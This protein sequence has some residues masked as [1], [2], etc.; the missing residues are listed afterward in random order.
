[1][2]PNILAFDDHKL[3]SVPSTAE[4][5]QF[6]FQWLSDAE[7]HLHTLNQDAL[8]A[9]QPQF[10][11]DLVRLITYPSVRPSKPVRDLVARCYV[12]LYLTGETRTLLDTIQRLRSLILA[13]Q[14]SGE[15]R[16]TKMAALH[17]L[18]RL[19]AALGDRILSQFTDCALLAL[20]FVRSSDSLPLRL[21]AM[22][23]LCDMLHGAGRIATDQTA[24]E[25]A[26]ALRATL[27]EKPTCIMIAA[28]TATAALVQHTPYIQHLTPADLDGF[29]QSQMRLLDTPVPVLRH[30]VADLLAATLGALYRHRAL[31]DV[32]GIAAVAAAASRA[33]GE[34]GVPT[35]PPVSRRMTRSMSSSSAVGV[36]PPIAGTDS[37]SM[38]RTVSTTASGF[39]QRLS[40]TTTPLFYSVADILRYLSAAFNRPA[41]SRSFRAGITAAYRRLLTAWGT[42]L[43]EQHLPAILRHVLVDLAGGV[44]GQVTARAERVALRVLITDLLRRG[45]VGDLLSDRGRLAAAR[46]ILTQWVKLPSQLPFPAPAGRSTASTTGAADATAAREL[47]LLCALHTLAGLLARLGND[48]AQIQ[49]GMTGSLLTLLSYPKHAVQTAAALCLREFAAAVPTRLPRLLARLV[50]LLQKDVAN[51][52]NTGIS[53]GVLKRCQGYALGLAAAVTVVGRRPL[54]VAHDLLQ[55]VAALAHQL[56]RSTLTTPGHVPSRLPVGGTPLPPTNTHPAPADRRVANA[57]LR[58]GWTLV[59][60]LLTLGPDVAQLHLAAWFTFWS[61]ALPDEE[62]PGVASAPLTDHEL[63]HRYQTREAALAALY[64]LLVFNQQLVDSADTARRALGLLRATLTFL[65]RYP[66]V[67]GSALLS[68]APAGSSAT[69]SSSATATTTAAAA[70]LPSTAGLLES[71]FACRRRLMACFARLLP[72]APCESL[73][74]ALFRCAQDLVTNPEPAFAG[75]GDFLYARAEGSS[76]GFTGTYLAHVTSPAFGSSASRW[77][78]EVSIGLSSLLGRLLHEPQH[79]RSGFALTEH[80]FNADDRD[81]LDHGF[82]GVPEYDVNS[83][84]APPAGW[85]TGRTGSDSLAHDGSLVVGSGPPVMTGMAGVGDAGETGNGFSD[86]EAGEEEEEAAA[87]DDDLGEDVDDDGETG[88]LDMADQPAALAVHPTVTSLPH[89]TTV[90]PYTAAIDAAVELFGTLFNHT[91]EAAQTTLLRDLLAAQSYA[92]YD[93]HPDRRYAV[94]VNGVLALFYALRGG[95]YGTARADPPALASRVVILMYEVL[96]APLLHSDVRLRIA[97]GET[98]GLLAQRAGAKFISHTVNQ[99]TMQAI[100]NRDPFARAGV[101]LGLGSIYSHAGSMTASVH[102]KSVVVLLH[103]LARD[104]HPVVHRWGL[105][106]LGMTIDAA[107]LMFVPYVSITVVLLTKLAASESH[108]HPLTAEPTALANDLPAS[109]ALRSLGQVLHAVLGAYGPELPLDDGLRRACLALLRELRGPYPAEYVRCCQQVLMFAPRELTTGPLLR[110]LRA[111]LVT[112]DPEARTAGAAG[113]LQ[114]VKRDASEVLHSGGREAGLP[115][116]FALYDA[117]PNLP[118]LGRAIRGLLDQAV[119]EPDAAARLGPLIRTLRTIVT[120]HPGGGAEAARNDGPA[121]GADDHDEEDASFVGSGATEGGSAGVTA[122]GIVLPPAFTAATRA[123][124]L[125]CLRYLLL[126]YARQMPAR[127]FDPDFRPLPPAWSALSGG[128]GGGVAELV[129]VA[130]IAASGSHIRLQREGLALLYVLLREFAGYADPDFTSVSLL[131]QYQAQ[132]TAAFAPL[133][134]VAGNPSPA[135]TTFPPSVLL[136]AVRLGVAFAVS[137]V[138]RDAAPLRRLLRPLAQPLHLDEPV[139]FDATT[140]QTSFA[141]DELSAPRPPAGD[142]ASA[143]ARERAISFRPSPTEAAVTEALAPHTAALLRLRLLRAWADLYRASRVRPYLRPLVE[144]QLGLLCPLWLDALTDAVLIPLDADLFTRS[145]TTAWTNASS[146]VTVTDGTRSEPPSPVETTEPALARVRSQAVFPTDSFAGG[147]GEGSCSSEVDPADLAKTAAGRSLGLDASAVAAVRTLL[148]GHLGREWVPIVDAFGALLGRGA[149]DALATL[150]TFNERT[151]SGLTASSSAPFPRGEY[152]VYGLCVR[153][154]YTAPK[155]RAHAA[156]VRVCLRTLRRVLQSPTPGPD[157]TTPLPVD[158]TLWPL[159]MP[160]AHHRPF[161]L[162]ALDD[163]TVFSEMWCVLDRLVQLEAPGVRRGIVRLAT[164]VVSL[165]QSNLLYRDVLVD[166]AAEPTFCHIRDLPASSR[167]WQVLA[168]LLSVYKHTRPALRSVPVTTEHSETPA[169]RVVCGS[170]DALVHLLQA[171]PLLPPTLQAEIAAMTLHLLT[172]L[173][174]DTPLA[175]RNAGAVLRSLRAWLS[176]DYTRA[177]EAASLPGTLPGESLVAAVAEAL[178]TVLTRC[179]VVPSEPLYRDQ[180]RASLGFSFAALL[181]SS[182][183][184]C[185]IPA[186]L[187]L[188]YLHDVAAALRCPHFRLATGALQSVRLLFLQISA[189]EPADA[190]AAATARRTA[191]AAAYVL[192]PELVDLLAELHAAPTRFDAG[193]DDYAHARIQMARADGL[194]LGVTPEA[195]SRQLRNE[196]PLSIARSV[197][198][199]LVQLVDNIPADQVPTLFS[200]VLPSLIFVLRDD[201]T[202][203][204]AAPQGDVDPIRQGF[205][206]IALQHLI[207][208][209]KAYSDAFKAVILA[210]EPD[211]QSKLQRALRQDALRHAPGATTSSAMGGPSGGLLN[212]SGPNSVRSN[213][214]L[215]GGPKI[216]LRTSFNSFA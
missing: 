92:G 7:S 89:A 126:R 205:H 27:T 197:C 209:A 149:P 168:L 124:A 134:A 75:M 91:T 41:A 113:L 66:L 55:W 215:T 118:D 181:V 152:L 114:L 13:K 6:I 187:V 105:H 69:S 72:H 210:L 14:G 35:G 25:L 16:E 98:L 159:A 145:A 122:T 190:E 23:A 108:A 48:A 36:S 169:V 1:M 179:C 139:D 112:P 67:N 87:G 28:T 116:L 45:V 172:Q 166:P 119:T 50:H 151:A 3:Q 177:A 195:L 93:R 29:V 65:E 194:D 203:F 58:M 182:L 162:V 200:V 143:L 202:T 11:V 137:G 158:S 207:G 189:A 155:T 31:E 22:A 71:H 18:G 115:T 82:Y 78:H 47:A 128:G 163:P 110:D 120:R 34:P 62:V 79:R 130:F 188:G 141:T 129:R 208:L 180:L 178:D 68:S 147:D 164:S 74:P 42:D 138:T 196:T 132:I 175:G 125:G 135:A 157:M 101:A 100:H 70:G 4:K 20:R 32:E 133:L 2:A 204:T 83:L 90:A 201:T 198:W 102:L 44:Q 54:Y 46:E 170:A 9:I 85:T 17:I 191:A 146:I 131:D 57:Q 121:T 96:R 186:D 140:S 26:K 148:A 95:Q 63:L 161:A 184:G 171:C 136:M 106:A 127:G 103:S 97:A 8:K 40:R 61:Q 144:P 37:I 160:D 142:P 111:A 99:L 150:Y 59:A 19:F 64:N 192:V 185:T 176:I 10:E 193:V 214:G 33:H 5:E 80:L 154:L 51:I 199:C 39:R 73:Y 86:D 15:P 206:T 56:L 24:R 77:G 117:Y 52:T 88:N 165:L 76:E 53:V 153:Y 38:P 21:V 216:Q 212:G 156:A 12:H 174:V 109:S 104:A 211:V 183:R 81:D 84:L 167:L 123:F 107:G 94:L 60:A 30:A 213:S 43:V 173:A 49:E